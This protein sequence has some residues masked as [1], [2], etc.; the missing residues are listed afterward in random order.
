[1]LAERAGLVVPTDAKH[2]ALLLRAKRAFE[3]ARKRLHLLR[4]N[5][6][7]ADSD[8]KLT[9]ILKQFPPELLPEATAVLATLPLLPELE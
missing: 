6:F 1:M 5:T 4:W 2:L 9:A 8:R 7:Y 3:S